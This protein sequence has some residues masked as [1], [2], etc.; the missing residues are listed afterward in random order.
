MQLTDD[1]LLEDDNVMWSWKADVLSGIT[2]IGKKSASAKAHLA[3]QLKL[4]GT[5]GGKKI[6]FPLAGYTFTVDGAGGGANEHP[7]VDGQTIKGYNGN[8]SYS[9]YNKRFGTHWLFEWV[10]GTKTWHYFPI[11]AYSD[12]DGGFVQNPYLEHVLNQVSKYG[13]DK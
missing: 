7:I 12:G 8:F 11:N 2:L 5:N 13:T 6:N 3:A 9:T 1:D 4:P 10:P